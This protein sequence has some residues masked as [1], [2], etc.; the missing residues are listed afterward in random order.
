[1]DEARG[2]Q[3][4]ATR[5]VRDLTTGSGLGFTSIGVRDLKGIADPWE[6]YAVTD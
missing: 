1:M 5:T 4:L 3:V 2:G 6:L